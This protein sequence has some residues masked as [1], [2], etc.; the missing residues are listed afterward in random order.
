LINTVRLFLH[1]CAAIFSEAAL[2]HTVAQLLVDGRRQQRRHA[3]IRSVQAALH[4]LLPLFLVGLL[5]FAGVW[6]GSVCLLGVGGIWVVV[7]GSLTTPVIVLEAEATAWSAV[8]R[9]Y[10]LTKG[11][12]W[13]VFKC[14]G[15]L[16]LLEVLLVPATLNVLILGVRSSGLYVSVWRT[17]ISALPAMI[18]V[19]ARALLKTI[20]YTSLRGAA[21]EGW[22]ARELAEE[23]GH[24]GLLSSSSLAEALDDYQPVASHVEEEE[25]PSEPADESFP[26][27]NGGYAL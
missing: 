15:T 3:W 2:C 14:L 24:V 12:R 8:Q 10:Q 11:A 5:L 19:P 20:L 1:Q 4:R 21:E 7:V 13:Y 27:E 23:L 16:V 6:L 26:E 17:L 25:D 9:S 18:F 22:G